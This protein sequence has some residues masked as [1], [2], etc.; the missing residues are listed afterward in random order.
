MP[1]PATAQQQP[2][3]KEAFTT[4]PMSHEPATAYGTPSFLQWSFYLEQPLNSLP[5]SIKEPPLLCFL[6]L[7]VFLL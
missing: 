2:G 6:D 3:Q 7:T 4:Q 1:P 5:S